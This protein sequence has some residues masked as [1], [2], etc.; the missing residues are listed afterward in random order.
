MLL[1]LEMCCVAWKLLL[2]SRGKMAVLGFIAA[3]IPRSNLFF[4]FLF[5]YLRITHLYNLHHNIAKFNVRVI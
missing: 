2:C 4:W 3:D 1:I 5:L